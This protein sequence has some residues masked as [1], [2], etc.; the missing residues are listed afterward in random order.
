MEQKKAI[1]YYRV[2]S[3]EQAKGYS[4]AHQ[5]ERLEAYCK[6]Q[7][8]EVI[9]HYREDHSAKSFERPEFKKILDFLKKHKNSADFL[10]FTK[11][12]RFSRNAGDAYSMI[13]TLRK[14]G[15]EPQAIEQPLDLTVPENKLMLAF[16]L[17]APEVENDR[18][19]L[20]I[21][22]G[23]RK[24]QREGRV[25]GSALIGYKNIRNER[26]MAL[27]EV[28]DKMS[29]IVI[30][31]FNKLAEGIRT[32]EDIRKE[33]LKKGLKMG[34]SHFYR[35]IRNPFYYGVVRV[36]K[37]DNIEEH[38]VKGLHKPLITKALF[39]AVQNVIEGRKKNIQGY[40][41]VRDVYPLR[42][43][44]QCK[45]CGGTLTASAST[46]N[47][48]VKYHYYHCKPACG[49]RFK[50]AQPN[51]E[52]QNI[53]KDV[54]LLAPTSKLLNVML[55]KF[56]KENTEAN[57]LEVN[58][59]DSQ[60]K[61]IKTR[62]ENAQLLMLDGEFP[63][64]EY[65][66]MKTNLEL[67]LESLEVKKLAMPDS[68]ATKDM[69]LHYILNNIENLGKAYAGGTVREKQLLISSTF[70]EKLIFDKNNYR[71]PKFNKVISLLFKLDKGLSKIKNGKE[72]IKFV[73]SRK[74]EDN[75][76]EP[77]T[78]CM[79]CKRSTN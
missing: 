45:K 74:V 67:D 52:M 69:F 7:G 16:Y 77:M 31:C 49:E 63:L 1:L 61:K 58:T 66:T 57:N 53:L 8:Y 25:C 29:K 22:A 30:W 41:C 47:K 60:I 24:A 15:V 37:H 68:S 75:G 5:K 40:E 20:N 51:E 28:D 27:V 13:S 10:I 4:L 59:I 3:D 76:F 14:F 19:A 48:G 18:R 2:S 65:K 9:A 35:F 17:A 12:D 71:T 43:Y 21:I 78:S 11:W 36:P 23:I 56:T 46:G 44:L 72:Q 32:V 34:K 79:P 42:G 62:L 38:L 55:N 64:N 54:S 73:N 26:G 39:D 70:E 33:A 50:I 6:I